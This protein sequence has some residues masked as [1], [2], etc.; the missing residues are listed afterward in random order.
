MNV[1]P[2]DAALVKGS[3][4]RIPKDRLDWPIYISDYE[5]SD[6]TDMEIDSNSIF[7]GILDSVDID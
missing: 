2:V 4:G 3:H 5:F 1:I 7:R 6:S